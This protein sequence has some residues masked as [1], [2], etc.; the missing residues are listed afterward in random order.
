[1]HP[2]DSRKYGRG[3]VLQN[4]CPPQQIKVAHWLF[5]AAAVHEALIKSGRVTASRFVAPP[6][7]TQ[8]ELLRVHSK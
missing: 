2:F 7:A 5:V 3:A 8:Q 1:M 6:M 4:H